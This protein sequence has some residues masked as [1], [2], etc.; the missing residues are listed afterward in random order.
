[1]LNFKNLKVWIEDSSLP[2]GGIFCLGTYNMNMGA[3][4]TSNKIL[5]RLQ[6]KAGVPGLLDVLSERLSPSELTSLM[7]EVYR[8]QAQKRTLAQ[9]L[10]DYEQNRFVRPSRVEV[11]GLLEW[12]QVTLSSLPDV[13]EPM[14]LAP[15]CPIG[16][17]SVL[18][19]VNQHW[20]VVTSRN[21]EVVSDAT[22]VLALEVASRRR[23]LL[24][25][26]PRSSQ[27]VHL[28]AH[29]R[30]LRPQLFTGPHQLAHFA[31]FALISGGRAGSGSSFELQA[32]ATHLHVHLT[33]LRAYLGSSLVLRVVI[34]DFSN[35]DRLDALESEVLVALR[36]NFENLTCVIDSERS[37][38]RGYYSGFVFQI[39]AHAGHEELFL[40]DG[41]EV[42][43]TQKL[44]A[45]AKER[46]IISGLG[47]ERVVIL[48]RDA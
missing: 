28:A 22:N 23:Q 48:A 19:G 42:N 1:M 8:R 47:S 3:S 21:S 40:V 39:Y 41:G 26:A 34:S 4:E 33:A 18:A 32:I 5:E 9:V 13:F 37:S 44:L 16:T 45:N 25:D 12:E 24:R 38:G 30:L 2:C 46:L 10:T 31:L 17:S 14:E 29:H 11:R 6:R 35:R 7:L 43:W 15:V 27:A 20:A 36:Q